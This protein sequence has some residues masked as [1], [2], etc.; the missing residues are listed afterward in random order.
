MSAAPFQR[1]I[2][3]H[4]VRT[5]YVWPWALDDFDVFT[6]QAVPFDE[7]DKF[8]FDWCQRWCTV[9]QVLPR[10]G[11]RGAVGCPRRVDSVRQGLAAPGLDRTGDGIGGSNITHGIFKDLPVTQIE[12]LVSN[13]RNSLG[14]R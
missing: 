3:A 6:M 13:S 11:D 9:P 8:L 4:G 2:A 14:I 5:F 1:T 12:A 10:S 7:V